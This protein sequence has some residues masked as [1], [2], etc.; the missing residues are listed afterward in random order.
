MI[1]ALK[2]SFESLSEVLKIC[3][4]FVTIR[5][6]ASP[7]S[8]AAL[9]TKQPRLGSRFSDPYGTLAPQLLVESAARIMRPFRAANITRSYLWQ[10]IRA[11]L[12][13]LKKP[14]VVSK[15]SSSQSCGTRVFS[16]GNEAHCNCDGDSGYPW[17]SP[18]SPTVLLSL[19]HTD[20]SDYTA[21]K[22]ESTRRAATA[23]SCGAGND[24]H[25]DERRQKAA[26]TLIDAPDR[27]IGSGESRR[28]SAELTLEEGHGSRREMMN[29]ASYE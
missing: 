7:R 27:A 29:P 13:Y 4:L 18:L 28:G 2:S 14:Y 8:I 3:V 15:V 17:L 20:L 10:C 6:E 26:G 24:S 5:S 22:Q 1:N 23:T 9:I 16:I 19:V 11:H 21:T 25:G 12:G